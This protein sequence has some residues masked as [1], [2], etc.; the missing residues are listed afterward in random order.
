MRMML[1]MCVW[2][3]SWHSAYIVH[4]PYYAY[5]GHFDTYVLRFFDV[6]SLVFSILSRGLYCWFPVLLCLLLL[7]GTQCFLVYPLL[8]VSPFWHLVGVLVFGWC[9]CSFCS[10]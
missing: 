2:R 1:C 4:L 6:V 7:L 10:C 9:L 5:E 3:V 8:L